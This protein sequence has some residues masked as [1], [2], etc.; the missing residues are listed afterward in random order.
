[1]A[2]NVK[3]ATFSFD[4]SVLE[5]LELLAKWMHLPNKSRILSQLIEKEFKRRQ[6]EREESLDTA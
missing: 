6:Q 1:V 2:L 4:P 5:K 3:V